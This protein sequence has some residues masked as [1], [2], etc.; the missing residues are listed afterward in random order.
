VS[1]EIDFFDRD[2]NYGLVMDLNALLAKKNKMLGDMGLQAIALAA[3]NQALR[4]NADAILMAEIERW[5]DALC[6][7][8]HYLANHFAV[9]GES[10]QVMEVLKV[11]S[12]AAEYGDRGFQKPWL[13]G[14]MA[15]LEGPEL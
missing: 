2:I 7:V 6:C 9:G 5:Q 13:A 10:I 15:E 12:E 11:L 1:E 4:E 14:A 3:E 8:E